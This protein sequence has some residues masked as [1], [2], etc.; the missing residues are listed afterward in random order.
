ME[1]DRTCAAADTAFRAEPLIGPSWS[2]ALLE[3]IAHRLE[4]DRSAIVEI[5]DRD[6]HLGATRLNGELTRTTDQLRQFAAATRLHYGHCDAHDPPDPAAAPSPTPDLKRIRVPIGPVAVFAASNF[7]L[8]FGVIGGDTASALAAGCPVI[9]RAHPLQIATAQRLSASIKQGLETVGAPE[10]W[11]GLIDDPSRSAGETLV[12]HPA[13]EAVG[14]TGSFSGGTALAAL[15]A[16]RAR[17]I[18]VFAEM[19][20]I[21]PLFVTQGASS[22]PQSSAL[23]DGLAASITLGAG[24]FCTKPGLIVLP[25]TSDVDR[26]IS[27]LVARLTSIPPAQMLSEEMAE[28]F[29]T[30]FK[31][32]SSLQGVTVLLALSD[33]TA[34]ANQTPGLLEVEADALSATHMCL[35]EL[36]GPAAVLTRTND[37]QRIISLLPGSLTATV[38]SRQDERA[39]RTE[40]LRSLARRSGRVIHN[41]FPTGVAVKPA[42]HHGGPYPSTNH[43]WATSVGLSAVERFRRPVTLQSWP[44]SDFEE[45]IAASRGRGASSWACRRTAVIGFDSWS[46][47]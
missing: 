15:A 27:E 45:I 2:P 10:K 14:F 3:A 41:G 46:S 29:R 22:A 16:Q 20:S 40:L 25:E 43:S 12:R 23:V 37:P 1:I 28:A 4:A 47:S 21:N 30:G 38:H 34:G 32:R 31:D 33:E 13:I 6:S 17:P 5:A 11:F 8:A 44:D 36:F 26:L 24:Q 7:P 19:G 9:A 18:P 39:E 42:M 35:T